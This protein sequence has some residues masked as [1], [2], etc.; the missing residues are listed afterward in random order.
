MKALLCLSI[1]PQQWLSIITAHLLLVVNY[2][3]ILT[4]LSLATLEPPQA[5]STLRLKLYPQLQ[6]LHME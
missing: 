4:C 3:A 2:A 1:L 6:T 5:V